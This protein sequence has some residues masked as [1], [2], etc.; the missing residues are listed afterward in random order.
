MIPAIVRGSSCSQRFNRGG[1]TR[2]LAPDFSL[3]YQDDKA[4]GKGTL[5]YMHGDKYV[6]DW[7]VGCRFLLNSRYHSGFETESH[8]PSAIQIHSC[9]RGVPLDLGARSQNR[10]LGMRR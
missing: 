7:Q 8:P 6:G 4:H 3:S 1:D 2:P 5:T 10:F 9:R